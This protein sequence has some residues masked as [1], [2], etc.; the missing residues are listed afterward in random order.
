MHIFILRI[1]NQIKKIFRN[2]NS[3]V[4]SFLFFGSF[5]Y[6]TIGRNVKI[7]GLKI[8]INKACHIMDN[9]SILGDVTVGHNVFIHENVLI[10]SFKERISIG[11][12]TTIN[13]NTNILSKVSIGCNCSIAPNVVIV[14]ANHN[15][16]D[17]SRTI[18]E[19]GCTWQG[20]IIE[21]DVWIAA[22]VTVCDGV[23]IGKG[24]VIGAGAV[25]V[26]DIPPFTVAV[27]VPAKVIKHR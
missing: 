27:G 13:R 9:S 22:N 16:L 21:D 19:Q 11:E 23:K 24:A 5:D 14:G 15:F 20:I 17:N 25:V 1:Y 10:R 7:N 6:I 18:K 26:N 8:N 4:F 3:Y 12:N 2:I